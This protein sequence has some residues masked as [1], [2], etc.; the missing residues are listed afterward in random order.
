MSMFKGPATLTTGSV[1]TG[2]TSITTT[3]LTVS[4][5]VIITDDLSAADITAATTFTLSGNLVS[6]INSGGDG[7]DSAILVSKSYTDTAIGYYE[8]TLPVVTAMTGDVYTT[9]DVNNYNAIFFGNTANIT[10][11][12]L[13]A[14]ITF[15]AAVMVIDY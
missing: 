10:G 3:D 14:S 12:A 8:K 11:T 2:A 1:I 5:D 6:S 9:I 4:N 7:A 15:T 13:T